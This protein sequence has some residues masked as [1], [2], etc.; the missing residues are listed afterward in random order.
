M[1]VLSFAEMIRIAIPVGDE[2]IILI[3]RQP[4]AKEQSTFLNARFTNKGK[5]VESHL[6]EARIAFTRSILLDVEN[7]SYLNRAGQELPLNKATVLSDDEK[8]H[9]SKTLGISVDS[10]VDLVSPTWLAGGAMYFEDAAPEDE[11]VPNS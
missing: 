6:Y 11:H 4:K 8:L 2:Q 3:V 7:A 9:A 1:P 5:K 10:W